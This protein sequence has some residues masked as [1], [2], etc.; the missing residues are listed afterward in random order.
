MDRW[1][2][3][4]WIDKLL[5]QLDG[6]IDKIQIKEFKDAIEIEYILIHAT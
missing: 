1:M 5:E 3:N 6:Q 2:D 4:E